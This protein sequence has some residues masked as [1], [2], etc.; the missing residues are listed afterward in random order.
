[1]ALYKQSYWIKLGCIKVVDLCIVTK[2]FGVLLMFIDRASLAEKSARNAL[3]ATSNY[4][5]FVA[6][7]FAPNEACLLPINHRMRCPLI[8]GAN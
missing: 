2:P 1:M 6:F 4:C 5:P 8:W 7:L 3:L